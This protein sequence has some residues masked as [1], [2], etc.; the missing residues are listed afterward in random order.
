MMP[1]D[2]PMDK[3][4]DDSMDANEILDGLK[5][6]LDEKKDSKDPMAMEAMKN[7]QDAIDA[8]EKVAGPDKMADAAPMMDKPM[9]DDAKPSDAV[10]TSVLT[11]PIGGLKNFLIKKSQDKE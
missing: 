3:P 6:L 9:D 7:I 4:M 2:K 8:M 5:K 11:G 1:M 10:D